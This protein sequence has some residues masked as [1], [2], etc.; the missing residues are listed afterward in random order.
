MGIPV[1][2]VEVG[3]DLTDSPIGPFFRLDDPVRGVLD[4]TDYLL[5][6]TI[7]IDITDRVRTIRVQRGRARNFTNYTAGAL[8]VEINNHDRAFDPLFTASPYYGNIVP[9]REIRITS[10]GVRQFTGWIDDWDLTYTPDGNSIAT[11]TAYDAFMILAKQALTGETPPEELTGARINRALDDAKVNWASNQRDIA[12]GQAT[13][14]AIPIEPET[15]VL[16][17]LQQVSLADP[18]ELF[19]SKNGYVV[20]KDRAEAPSSSGQ[21]ILGEGGI[22]FKNVQVVY[23][24]EDLYNNVVVSRVG[25]GT[26]I[27]T[28]E[29]SQDNYGIRTLEE[30]DLLLSSDAQIADRAS[31]LVNWYSEPEYRFDSVEIELHKR[32]E[33]EQASILSLELGSFVRIIFTPN[34]I[35]PAINRVLEVIRLEHTI[36]PTQH[37]LTVGFQSTLGVPLVL[38][39]L[40][41]GKL[42]T[43]TLGW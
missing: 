38:D 35:A 10:G 20:F 5:G 43:A 22:P 15:N 30:T 41:F 7:F 19:M 21:V 8:S 37:F 12:T 25:G 42:D 34:G 1:P 29:L 39:D 27:A 36:T 14:G 18:G 9:R 17:Y 32:T 40:E 24:T 6:G 31:V 23:G 26:A 13:V 33:S 2:K 3:F 28:N 16:T 11:A 4:N